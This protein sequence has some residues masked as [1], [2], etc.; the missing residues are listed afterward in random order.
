MHSW[1]NVM[2]L[3]VKTTSKTN[4]ELRKQTWRKWF[5]QFLLV[6]IGENTSPVCLQFVA[7]IGE[8][9]NYL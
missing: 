6:E 5:S 4:G 8:E 1:S 7:K 2:T 3:Q 9:Y